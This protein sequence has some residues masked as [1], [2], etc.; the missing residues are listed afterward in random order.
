MANK[1]IISALMIYYDSATS[2]SY[3]R[4]FLHWVNHNTGASNT[5]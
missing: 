5:K 2:Q 3:I 1:N 4:S